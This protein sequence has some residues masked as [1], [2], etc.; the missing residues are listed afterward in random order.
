MIE[1]YANANIFPVY[2]DITR[3]DTFE[4]LENIIKNENID[5]LVNCAGGTKVQSKNISDNSIND[6]NED[7]AINVSGT[8]QVIKSVSKN[9]LSS[10]NPLI[11]TITSVGGYP[12]RMY[13]VPAPYFLAKSSESQLLNYL[14]NILNPI[15]LTELVIST[16]N[17]FEKEEQKNNSIKTRD[18][19]EFIKFLCE[20]PP[21]LTIDKIHLRHINSGGA[22]A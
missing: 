5:V 1:E 7:F 8:F 11:I 22:V 6:F 13:D 3:E 17:T 19:F 15:R 10:S 14:T 9:M 12:S 20:S 18:V 4:K 21:Y 2:L 16:V